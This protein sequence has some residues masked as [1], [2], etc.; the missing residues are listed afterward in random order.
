MHTAQR[1]CAGLEL[2]ADF[3]SDA[4]VVTGAGTYH[5]PPVAWHLQIS[6]AEAN[7]AHEVVLAEVVE[8]PN[9]QH[10]LVGRLHTAARGGRK[11]ARNAA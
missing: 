8:V 11:L 7:L 4:V 6:I 1:S 5:D 9:A 2:H 10:Q 3:A